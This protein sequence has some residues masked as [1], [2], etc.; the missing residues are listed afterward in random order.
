MVPKQ[1]PKKMATIADREIKSKP[2]RGDLLPAVHKALR[3]KAADQDKSMAAL[4][5]KIISEHL[6]FKDEGGGK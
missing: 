3:R 4:A 5:R 1:S 2:V 6:G